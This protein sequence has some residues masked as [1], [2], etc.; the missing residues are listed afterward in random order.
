MGPGEEK[1]RKGRKYVLR[2]EEKCVGESLR[3]PAGGR[4]SCAR[5]SQQW[6]L[7]VTATDKQVSLRHN[8]SLPGSVTHRAS[9]YAHPST[10][11]LTRAGR[12][13]PAHAAAPAASPRGEPEEEGD[14]C[15]L[16]RLREELLKSS[17]GLPRRAGEGS[18]KPAT[19]AGRAPGPRLRPRHAVRAG[20]LQPPRPLRVPGSEPQEAGAAVPLALNAPSPKSRPAG[21]EAPRRSPAIRTLAED[22]DATRVPAGD[23][24]APRL[25]ALSQ[26]A[27]GLAAPR[28]ARPAAAAAAGDWLRPAPPAAP[29][30]SSVENSGAHCA[31][32][33]RAS[34]QAAQQPRPGGAA[35]S[36]AWSLAQRPGGLPAD[37]D[38]ATAPPPLSAPSP[39]PPAPSPPRF[40]HRP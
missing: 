16:L 31:D 13:R 8:P 39:L 15:H 9:L 14:K 11:S 38:P 36:P 23:H 21:P 24:P 12:G 34:S 28:S 3:V 40:Q 26:A 33:R 29:P 37:S 20:Q 30:S 1:L 5:D 4:C 22:N 27:V 32:A 18:R 2:K 10:P 19:P 7:R 25:C 35:S 17:Q 6:P